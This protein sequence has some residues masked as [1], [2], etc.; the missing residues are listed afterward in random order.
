MYKILIVEDDDTIS[1]IMKDKLK[2][3]GYDALIVSD[4]NNVLGEYT[5][6]ESHL[7]L[8]DINLPYYDGFYWCAKIRQISNV[9][10]I[11][12]SSRD[13]EGDKIR[14][15]IQGGD[16]YI[17]KPF[18]LDMLIVK[19]Q[20]ILRRAYSYSDHTLNVLQHRNIILNIEDSRIFCG[21]KEI[22]LT[23][24]ECKILALLMRNSKKTITRP[25]LIKA[26][27]DDESFVDD[28]TLTVN[29]NRLRKKLKE[30]GCSDYIETIK[31][32]GYKLI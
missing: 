27:W 21:E 25:R 13:T 3:W 6:F 9:P 15:I 20:A 5:A 10:I 4:F 18:S 23:H 11:F 29:I 7:V 2:N 12:I 30:L 26:L 1:S 32:E 16:D 22:R 19:V 8:M 31:G 14:G 17:E 24:N 28:N